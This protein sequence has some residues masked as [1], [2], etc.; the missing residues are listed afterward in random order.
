MMETK[1]NLII[2][3]VLKD[4]LPGSKFL[5]SY[6]NDFEGDE[7]RC[8]CFGSFLLA[9]CLFIPTVAP[10]GGMCN[11]IKEGFKRKS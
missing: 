4:F 1:F 8:G 7:W 10:G 9:G 11:E 2:D 5:L 3:D 6:L